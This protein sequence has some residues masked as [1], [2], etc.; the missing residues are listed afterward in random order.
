MI[1]QDLT[2]LVE[3]LILAC[4]HPDNV[5]IPKLCQHALQP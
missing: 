3:V 1:V 4:Y 2:A 5:P